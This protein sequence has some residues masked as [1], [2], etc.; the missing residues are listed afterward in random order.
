MLIIQKCEQCGTPFSWTEVYQSFWGWVYRSI[1]CN[2]CQTEHKITLSGRIVW[3]S[4]T[5]VPALV[6]GHFLTP[7][8]NVLLTLLFSLI[9]LLIGSLFTPFLV[10]F[11]K[12]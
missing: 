8:H 2:T 12:S 9:V 6:F 7:F 3:T 4:L 10:M 11:K 5:I 1:V